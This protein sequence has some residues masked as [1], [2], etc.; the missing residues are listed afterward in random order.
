VPRS[1]WGLHECTVHRTCHCVACAPSSGQLPVRCRIAAAHGN[2]AAQSDV[3][4]TSGF[5]QAAPA[6][7]VSRSSAAHAQ[8]VHA[9]APPV[10]PNPPPPYQGQHTFVNSSTPMQMGWGSQSTQR[11]AGQS[12]GYNPSQPAGGFS[13]HDSDWQTSAP[14]LPPD[15]HTFH[16]SAVTNIQQNGR[17]GPVAA[18]TGAGLQ[19]NVAARVP[20]QPPVAQVAQALG[21][22]PT[23]SLSLAGNNQ[24][25]TN[26]R[27]Q[28][29]FSVAGSRAA[30]DVR[31]KPRKVSSMFSAHTED[32]PL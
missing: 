18:R 28:M 10:P 16:Q 9:C 6:S 19:L 7:A 29:S 11:R 3:P 30:A 13:K 23:I 5:P 32:E 17:W 31:P 2:K 26:D 1:S 24:A 8:P 20:P 21:S 15:P 27:P 22:A 4:E 12:I 25:S 14:P